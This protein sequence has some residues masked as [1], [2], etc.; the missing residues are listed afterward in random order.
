M[1]RCPSKRLKPLRHGPSLPDQLS[2]LTRKTFQQTQTPCIKSKGCQLRFYKHYAARKISSLGNQVFGQTQTTGFSVPRASPGPSSEAV[3]S[4]QK[5]S[6]APQPIPAQSP[7]R[8]GPGGPWTRTWS[9]YTGSPR[10]FSMCLQESPHIATSF[11]GYPAVNTWLPSCRSFPP[12][13]PHPHMSTFV[14][15]CI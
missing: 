1:G 15:S 4:I 6:H 3:S 9:S 12:P 10:S 11:V 14:V 7:P 5:V 2:K 13:L 8:G